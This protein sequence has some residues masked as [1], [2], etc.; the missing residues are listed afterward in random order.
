MAMISFKGV[1]EG[2][3]RWILKSKVLVKHRLG[4]VEASQVKTS[5]ACH[6]VMQMRLAMLD[7]L[8]SL[9]L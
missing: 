3:S 2:V 4:I 8:S 1:L 6:G 5:L 7:C 9:R